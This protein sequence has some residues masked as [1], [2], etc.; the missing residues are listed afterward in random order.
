MLTIH[1]SYTSPYVRRTRILLADKE[2]DFKLV[3]IFNPDE[4]AALKRVNPTIKI[5]M[6]QDDDQTLYDSRVIY[7]YIQQKFDLPTLSWEQENLLTVIDAIND[8]L[9]QMFLLSRSGIDTSPDALYFKNQ[10][11]RFA[12]A[13]SAIEQAAAEQQFNE[14]HYPAICLFCLV[15][16]VL[17]RNLYDLTHYP[18]LLAFHEQYK[19]RQ[20]CLSTAPKE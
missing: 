2:H 8:S 5:P 17:F 3:N 13:F 18:N 15:D 7:R 20:D 19:N 16:W 12:E 11:D 14:W 1:G 10:R 6:L 4:K 9:V